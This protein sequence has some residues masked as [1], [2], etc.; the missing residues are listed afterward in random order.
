M[1]RDRSSILGL[2]VYPSLISANHKEELM[3]TAKALRPPLTIPQNT[4]IA[5]AMALP[6]Q[7]EKQIMPVFNKQDSFSGDQELFSLITDS[8]CVANVVKR[9]EGSLLKHTDNEI[10]YSYL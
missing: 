3:V 10:L 6:S 5:Q 2:V 7:P 1:A 9:L 8:A 4:P